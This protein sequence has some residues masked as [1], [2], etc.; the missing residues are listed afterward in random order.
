M[1]FQTF[2]GKKEKNKTTVTV[3]NHNPKPL[4]GVI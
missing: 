1:I 3:A 4:L 2:S